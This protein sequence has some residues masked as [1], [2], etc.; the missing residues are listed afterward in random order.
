MGY[1]IQ[2][3]YESKCSECE[4]D[5]SVGDRVFYEPNEKYGGGDAYCRP[6]GEDTDDTGDDDIQ[7]DV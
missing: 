1:W 4:C 7:V 6:C 2:S 3:P 5:I